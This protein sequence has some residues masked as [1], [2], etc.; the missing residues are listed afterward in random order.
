MVA[1]AQQQETLHLD[2]RPEIQQNSGFWPFSLYRYHSQFHV[3]VGP[4]FSQA[5]WRAWD[6][7]E[8]DTPLPP[9]LGALVLSY[10][11][12]GCSLSSPDVL[13]FKTAKKL[14]QHLLAEH[15]NLVATVQEHGPSWGGDEYRTMWN[16]VKLLSS[17]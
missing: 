2:W 8:K 3:D 17:T 14:Q 10:M 4:Y 6:V 11:S 7:L 9:E 5:C 13:R 16:D 15:S 12:F 1:A